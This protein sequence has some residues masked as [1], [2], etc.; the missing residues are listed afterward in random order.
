MNRVGA[1]RLGMKSTAARVTGR[2]PFGTGAPAARERA[3]CR[4]GTSARRLGNGPTTVSE[5]IADPPRERAAR[6]VGT[7]ARRLQAVMSWRSSRMS[8]P[9]P[10]RAAR[11]ALAWWA[12]KNRRPPV[13]MVTR[14]HARAPQASQRS[15]AVKVGSGTAVRSRVE[16]F[17]PPSHTTDR[18]GRTVVHR[19][20]NRRVPERPRNMPNGLRSVSEGAGRQHAPDP[21]RTP[22]IRPGSGRA[23][24][25][26]AHCFLP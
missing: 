7:S 26:C 20:R 22:H 10:T 13:G 25:R 19:W 18:P 15:A 24:R 4:L 9:E 23:A 17:M 14:T 5:R 2:P 21:P 6:R 8:A 3:V 11:C 16:A 12:Q 1:R